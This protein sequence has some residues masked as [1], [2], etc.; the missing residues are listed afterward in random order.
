[1]SKKPETILN[2]NV[3][4]GRSS[5]GNKQ[6]LFN[7]N[8]SNNPGYRWNN[9][10][11]KLEFTNDGTTWYEVQLPASTTTGRN[12][13][14][15]GAFDYWQRVAGNTSTV[16]TATTSGNFTADRFAYGSSGATSKN[17]SV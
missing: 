6:L 11:S 2:D 5:A 3:L 7:I 9:S 13:I 12:Y 17:Y 8:S 14:I 10:T 16:N 4:L 15:N 1:M